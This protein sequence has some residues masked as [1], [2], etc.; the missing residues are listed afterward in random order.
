MVNYS[1][2]MSYLEKYGSYRS[3]A[4]HVGSGTEVTGVIISFRISI[5]SGSAIN[6]SLPSDARASDKTDIILHHVVDNEYKVEYKDAGYISRE[7]TLRDGIATLTGSDG[8]ELEVMDTAY[9]VAKEADRGDFD[10]LGSMDQWINAAGPALANVTSLWSSDG[11]IWSFWL[12]N[13]QLVNN[14]HRGNDMENRGGPVPVDRRMRV[15]TDLVPTLE[16]SVQS[17]QPKEVTEQTWSNATDEDQSYDI[18][19]S[20]SRGTSTSLTTT[21][22]ASI[23]VSAS[24]A[25]GG[26][27]ASVSGSSATGADANKTSNNQVTNEVNHTV[28]VKAHTKLTLK[29]TVSELVKNDYYSVMVELRGRYGMPSVYVDSTQGIANESAWRHPTEFGSPIGDRA[30]SKS[31]YILHTSILSTNIEFVETKL[32]PS[33]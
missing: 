21:Q 23:N 10:T 33:S 13:T 1:C 9:E 3:V 22:S 30:R 16:H 14:R 28:V 19:Y 32:L 8:Q 12:N 29:T 17:S 24:V 25:I 4:I 7:I 31:S 27:N 20:E 15:V 5:G 11:V 26:F 6:K 18:R 2:T